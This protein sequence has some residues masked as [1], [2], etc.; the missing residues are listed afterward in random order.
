VRDFADVVVRGD[1]VLAATG[2][3][4]DYFVALARVEDGH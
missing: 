2:V 4:A 1:I 3:T